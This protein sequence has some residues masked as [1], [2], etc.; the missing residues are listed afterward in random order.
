MNL[1]LLFASDFHDPLMSQVSLSGHRREHAVSV[2]GVEIGSTLKVGLING[3]MGTAM[4]MGI[5]DTTLDLHVT[6][7]EPPPAPL[8]LTLIC[9]LPRPKSLIKCI[10]TATAM[11]VKR[12]LFIN[13]SRVEKDYWGSRGLEESALLRHMILGLEQA[14]DTLLPRIEFK[15][16]FKWFIEDDLPG[17]ITG[18][19]ALVAHP[20]AAKPCPYNYQ[21]PTTLIIGP[22]GGF[23]PHEIEMLEKRGVEAVSFGSRILRVEHAVAALL[24]RIM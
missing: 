24:G 2:C 19:R 21:G 5:T 13:S 12:M 9:A 10:E 8:P 7:N 1:I 23:V 6:L 3:N 4:V 18:S 15:R 17:I 16:R 11:G 14:R 22:E 20:Y